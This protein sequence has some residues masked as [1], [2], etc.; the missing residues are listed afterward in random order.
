[1]KR[2]TP[3]RSRPKPAVPPGVAAAL[4]ARSGG[5][6]EMQLAGCA[7]RAT[8]AA[9]RWGRGAG[10]THRLSNVL[11]ACRVCHSWCHARVAEAV[12]MGLMLRRGDDPQAVP[13]SYRGQLVVLDDEG[14][15]AVT[16]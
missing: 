12:D 16:W 8:D 14:G 7:G 9:H 5:W 10:G 3:L 13:V 4:A 2:R 15:V 6:C 1:M 11:Y